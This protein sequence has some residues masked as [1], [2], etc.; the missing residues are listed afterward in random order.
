MIRVLDLAAFG[1][2]ATGFALVAMPSI[3][4]QVLLGEQ[5]TG[6]GIPTARVA[7][8]ALIALSIACWRNSGLPGMLIYSAAVTV[9]LAYVGLWG[10]FT[11]ILLWPGVGLHLLLSILLWRRRFDIEAS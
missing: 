1:E 6:V 3:V 5:L 10:G 2:I 9:Y 7:G 8:I 11:G 4:G